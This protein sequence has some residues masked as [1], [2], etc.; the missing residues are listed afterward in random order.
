MTSETYASQFADLVRQ[1]IRLKQRF[2]T[3]MPED[4]ARTR[5]RIRDLL[6]E[7]NRMDR[8]DYDLLYRVGSL[9]G[10][11]EIPMTMG[12]LASAAEVPLSTATRLVDTLVD[13]GYAERL[14]DPDDRRVV[15]VQFTPTGADLYRTL[16]ELIQRR[17]TSVLHGFSDEECQ[18]LLRLA[19][20]V[21]HAL[22]EETS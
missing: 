13:N 22:M 12:E 14:S 16:D 20:K 18:S 10:E 15:R 5:A 19:N 21:L 4:A 6:P 17:I 8:A 11:G 3:V 1:A 9:I 7:P 2:R